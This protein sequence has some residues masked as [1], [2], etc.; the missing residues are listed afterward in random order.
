MSMLREYIYIFIYLKVY[1]H[2]PNKLFI[3][4]L[5][6]HSLQFFKANFTVDKR[7]F[8]EFIF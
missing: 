3:N 6:I 2:E 4:Y 7:K 1:G 8:I 5:F